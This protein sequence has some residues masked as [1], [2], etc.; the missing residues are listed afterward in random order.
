MRCY[1]DGRPGDRAPVFF[2]RGWLPVPIMLRSVCCLF[3]LLAALG[4]GSSRAGESTSAAPAAAPTALPEPAATAEPSE[5]PPPWAAAIDEVRRLV[6]SSAP[7]LALVRVD[8]LQSDPAADLAAWVAW[9]EV[10]FDILQARRD[11]RA[12]ALR[13]AALPPDAP[14][15][16]RD[17]AA[18]LRADAL[19]E[20][21]EAD[22]ALV[23]ARHALF[24]GE[25]PPDAAALD[26]A[27][28]QV[29]RA[30]AGTGAH[31]DAATAIQ[32]HRQDDAKGAAAWR[33][34]E[35]ELLLRGGD[36]AR[37]RTA[38]GNRTDSRSRALALLADL[39]RGA[40]APAPALEAAVKLAAELATKKDVVE[41][42]RALAWAVVAEAAVAAKVPATRIAALEKALVVQ[43][44]EPDRRALLAVTSDDLWA[45]YR[46][47]G[48]ALGN[49]L[50]LVVGSER[51]WFLAASNRFDA[52]PVAARAL[53]VVIAETAFDP[54]QRV[55]AE[56][57]FAQLVA[58][59]RDG[60]ALLERLYLSGGRFATP[61]AVPAPVRYLLI[62]PTLAL[63]DIPLASRLLH[64][65]DAPPEGAD[66]AEWHLRRARV[67][68]L[69]DRIDEGIAALDA[70]LAS[71]A[72]FEVDRF[73]QVVFDLQTLEEHRGA[74]RYLEPLLAQPLPPQQ[75]R[76][77][78]FWTADSFSALGEHAE[79]ARLYLGSATA[80]D[81]FAM[82]PWAQTARYRAA[83]ELA[84]GGLVA[85]AR[86]QF[87]ALQNATNDPARQAVLRHE[88]QQ[89]TLEAERPRAP[90]P[91]NPRPEP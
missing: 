34:L 15:A 38:L 68:V 5:P 49:Q 36:P 67:F 90:E 29:V 43:G 88:L 9:E 78:L 27:R 84:K 11:W 10:R 51:D 53:S 31:A 7:D 24:A 79:A 6:R 56:W 23:A 8:L 13:T 37:A 39:R 58:R 66:P 57:Q 16:L 60:G 52:E 50:E 45:A 62:D 4:A 48:L 26:R 65:L 54:E 85:D 32:R 72:P 47:Y 28:R 76:E 64:G 44:R 59:E 75:R 40:L 21:G 63:P 71:G 69:A 87:T 55:V 17:R 41:G 74:L 20:L 42:N 77:L 25:T 35:A 91:A 22:A 70:L 12:L 86:R 19:L 30:H 33:S 82:D 73:L 89:L 61:E 81:P 83:Q 1:D 46:E 14:A 2:F 18:A 3:V 80:L